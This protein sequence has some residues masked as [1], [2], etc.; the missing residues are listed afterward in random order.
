MIKKFYRLCDRF[1]SAVSLLKFP[2]IDY[3]IVVTYLLIM[4]IALANACFFYYLV[5]GLVTQCNNIIQTYSLS[6]TKPFEARTRRFV[7]GDSIEGWSDAIKVLIKSYLGSKRSSKVKF[8]YSDIRPKGARLVTSG[9]KAPGPQPL[10]EC[11]VK[12]KGILD[13]KTRRQ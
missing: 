6:I 12:I 4:L 13:W 5:A 11:L 8:D 1:S 10:K 2:R 9:G 3:T 7:I